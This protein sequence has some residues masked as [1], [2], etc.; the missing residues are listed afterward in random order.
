[1]DN[2]SELIIGVLDL[3]GDVIEHRRALE[4]CGAKVVSV[5]TPRDLARVHGLVIPGGESTTISKLMKWGGLWEAICERARSEPGR[6]GMPIY[7]TCAGAILLAKKVKGGRDVPTLGLMDIEVERNS[8]GRQL[9]SF[10]GEVELDGRPVKAIFIR[11]PRIKK[12]GANVIPLAQCGSDTVLARE[13]NLLVSTFH[14]E[15]TD[16]LTI[17]RTFLTLV[18]HAQPH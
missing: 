10:E 15:L 7:G 12:S 2:F 11:A 14:P 6:P 4:E 16:D 5:K 13:G 1:M 17:H 9:E 3:Q 18:R 8:Y